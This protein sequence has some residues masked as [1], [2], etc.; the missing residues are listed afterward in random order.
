VKEITVNSEVVGVS[1]VLL[2]KAWPLFT[3]LANFLVT[4]GVKHLYTRAT[5]YRWAI[6]TSAL[7]FC[8]KQSR[9][10]FNQP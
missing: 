3:N 10:L 9:Q 2:Y 6:S 1:E 4:V 5:A 7:S 8:V